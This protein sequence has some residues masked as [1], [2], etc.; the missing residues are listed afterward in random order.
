MGRAVNSFSEWAKSANP[1][2]GRNK[3][4][5]ENLFTA[6][7]SQAVRDAVSTH[8]DPFNRRAAQ[9]FLTHNNKNLRVICEGA[10]Q[11]PEYIMRKVQE[12]TSSEKGWN[13]KIPS[14]AYYHESGKKRGPKRKRLNNVR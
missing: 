6:I 2:G 14:I 5:E 9:H 1:L 12:C 8:V 7:L 4:P 13:I 10:G 3:T 11:D